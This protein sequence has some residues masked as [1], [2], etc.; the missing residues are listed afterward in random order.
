MGENAV[1]ATPK[2]PWFIPTPAKLVALL[3]AVELC[4]LLIHRRS[5]YLC[6]GNV[7]ALLVA[8]LMLLVW[9][10]IGFLWGRQERSSFQFGVRTLS[11]MVCCVVV[12][13]VWFG[14][15]MGKAKKQEEAVEAIRGLGGHVAYDY[16]DAWD[17]FS[18][19]VTEPPGPDWL[20]KMV[21]VDFLAEVTAVDLV[22]PDIRRSPGMPRDTSK[23]TDSWVETYITRLT[24]LEALDL[25]DTQITDSGLSHLESLNKLEALNL[26]N[27]KITDAGLVHLKGLGNLENL[28]LAGTQ[29]TDAG[30]VHL[31]EFTN[32]NWLYVSRTQIT[33]GGV[34]KLREALPNCKIDHGPY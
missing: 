16:N 18:P 17:Y 22:V 33:D 24:E 8:F 26:V 13:G 19:N 31:I 14:W 10:G 28:L 9:F 2:R 7:A 5:G 32:L 1:Q 25:D 11:L 4:L 27:T 34:R 12:V 30:I 23:F 29:L 6:L 21:G 20:R 3:L 15:R